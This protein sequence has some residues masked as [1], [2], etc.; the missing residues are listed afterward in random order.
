MVNPSN[1][2]TD[3][4]LILYFT[5]AMTVMFLLVGT[6]LLFQI[7]TLQS[8]HIEMEQKQDILLNKMDSDINA[9]GSLFD[10]IK[11]TTEQSNQTISDNKR[12]TTINMKTL[13]NTNILTQEHT[14]ILKDIRDFMN[15]SKLETNTK[16]Q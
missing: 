4:K 15:T 13:N 16:Q 6:V 9:V 11:H 2:T 1:I 3:S 14:E 7:F 12:M 8:N 5:G 10:Y